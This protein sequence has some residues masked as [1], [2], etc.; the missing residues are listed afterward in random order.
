[1]MLCICHSCWW[2]QRYLLLGSTILVFL[3][4]EAQDEADASNSARDGAVDHA[5]GRPS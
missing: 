4:L 5:Y 3:V 2:G 1:M